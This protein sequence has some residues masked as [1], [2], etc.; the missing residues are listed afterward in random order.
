MRE[1]GGQS[2]L[3]PSRGAE[4]Q[5]ALGEIGKNGAGGIHSP[6]TPEGAVLPR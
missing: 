1:K 5:R 6:V 2:M 4:R 3:F